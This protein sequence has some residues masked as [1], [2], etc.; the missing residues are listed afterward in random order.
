RHLPTPQHISS[1][2]AAN[3]HDALVSLLQK[4]CAASSWDPA[5][6]MRGSGYR[7]LM[8]VGGKVDPLVA[9]AASHAGLMGNDHAP[10]INIWE[11][12]TAAMIALQ[13]G[14]NNGGVNG[15]SIP[16]RTR[17]TMKMPG[18]GHP[19]NNVANSNVLGVHHNGLTMGHS[20][21]VNGHQHHHAHHVGH[22]HSHSNGSSVSGSVEDMSVNGVQMSPRL[23]NGGL[24]ISNVNN[25]G[26]AA[27]QAGQQGKPIMAN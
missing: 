18:G 24:R 14:L 13:N 15:V 16:Q 10:V 21:H 20:G 3:F 23:G 19:I 2:Q 1:D 8:F 11:D 5:R 4:K 27:Q 26:S 25:A 17:V 7:S 9:K 12:R 6:P 22:A